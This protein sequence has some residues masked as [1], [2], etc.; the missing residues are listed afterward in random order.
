VRRSFLP[1]LALAVLLGCGG[2]NKSRILSD[3]GE[4]PRH[5]A[6]GVAPFLDPRGKGQE[7]ADAIEAG[8]Q[9]L[10]YEP[11]DQ[12]A[13]AAALASNMPDRNS[14]LGIESLEYIKGKV[15]VDA[16]IFG[17]IAPDWSTVL[18]T[19]DETDMGGPILQAVLRPRRRRK[20]FD[21]P[22]EIAKEAVRLLTSLR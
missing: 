8:L 10:M 7:V 15:P 1:L 20:T 19:V 21:G 2:S 6:V 16:I 4:F 22:D 13:L 17:R 18:I 3:A 5:R 9:Q 14:H 12:K 11:V